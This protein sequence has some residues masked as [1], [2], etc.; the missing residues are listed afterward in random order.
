MTAGLWTFLKALG[1]SPFPCLC[2]LPETD[3]TPWLVA[4]SSIFHTSSSGLSPSHI[5]SLQHQL[6]CHTLY[7]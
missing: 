7:F 4:P 2:P 5:M 3:H 6:F 1:E